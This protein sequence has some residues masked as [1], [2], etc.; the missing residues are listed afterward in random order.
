MCQYE[1]KLYDSRRFMFAIK[2]CK[3]Q[4]EA[5]EYF[6]KVAPK[7]EKQGGVATIER[8]FYAKEKSYS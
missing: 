3:T 6:L 5:D 1:V 7:L 2:T 4:F 8:R